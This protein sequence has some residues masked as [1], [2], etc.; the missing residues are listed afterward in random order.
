MPWGEKIVREK[1]SVF[2]FLFY[3]FM[4]LTARMILKNDKIFNCCFLLCYL[5]RTYSLL[6]T[7]KLLEEDFGR[8][9]LGR[10][11]CPAVCLL[12]RGASPSGTSSDSHCS[13]HSS[14]QNW[15]RFFFKDK[16]SLDNIVTNVVHDSWYI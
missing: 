9:I 6:L 4:Y 14:L 8:T 2:Y 13:T 7:S 1:C 12:F 3:N 16:L 5:L 15:I 11:R 10:T